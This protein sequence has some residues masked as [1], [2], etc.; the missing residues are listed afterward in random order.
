M[1]KS[2]KVGNILPKIRTFK[3]IS[4]LAFRITPFLTGILF[5]LNIIQSLIPLGSAWNTKIIFDFLGKL[6]QS[7]LKSTINPLGSF[8]SLRSGP[9][10]FINFIGLVIFDF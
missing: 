1:K 5:V 9:V 2:K 8:D 4:V 6:F 10:H 7:D 3:E